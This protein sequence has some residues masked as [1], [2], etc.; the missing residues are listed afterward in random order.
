MPQQTVDYEVALELLHHE[1]I[2]R[3]AY[4]DSVGVLT[5]AVGMTNA[6]GHR[7]ERYIGKPAPMF[8]VLSIFVWALKNYSRAVDKAFAGYPLTKA[9]YAAAVLF[10]W[11][12]GAI[13]RA[14]WVELVKRGDM[15]AAREAFLS[16]NKPAEIRGRRKAEA[17]LFFDGVWAAKDSLV[18]EYTK[19]NPK[20]LAPIWSSAI[21]VDVGPELR[22]AFGAQ[23]GVQPDMPMQPDAP[24]NTGGAA[25]PDKAEPP[26]GIPPLVFVA[27]AVVLGVA[28]WI[29]SQI[30]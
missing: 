21:K 23:M 4:K 11:N 22:K 30:V 9:Q 3:Q 15:K 8:Q 1:A 29:L 19:V 13:E 27:V 12:T 18:T 28:G 20:T 14:T 2:V 16:W 5:W 24:V 7:V 26:A 17:D 6:T 10:H 25:S